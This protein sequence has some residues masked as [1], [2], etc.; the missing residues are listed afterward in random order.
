MHIDHKH[1]TTL[2]L[3][4]GKAREFTLRRDDRG[5]RLTAVSKDETVSILLSSDDVRRIRQALG[6]PI[7]ER[8]PPVVVEPAPAAGSYNFPCVTAPVAS[9]QTTTVS[10]Q[11]STRETRLPFHR[12]VFTE[13][14]VYLSGS[15]EWM[16]YN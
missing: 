3:Q 4:D 14:M 8:E 12:P 16:G 1:V 6:E 9:E 13:T 15:E 7:V 10:L 5:Y 2:D 11:T